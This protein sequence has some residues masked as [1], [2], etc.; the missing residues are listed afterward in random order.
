MQLIDAREDRQIWARALRSHARGFAQAW[1]ANWRRKS[2]TPCA[3]SSRPTKKCAS[4]KSRRPNAD[5][6]ALYLRALPARTGPDT[7]LQDYRRRGGTLLPGDRSSIRTSP[8][9]MPGSPPPA[10]RFII[11]TNRSI[12]G[13]TRRGAKRKPP[14]ACNPNLAKRHFALGLCALLV[15]RQIM[16]ARCANLPS[17]NIFRLT[18][19]TSARCRRHHSSAGALGGIARRLRASRE[20]RPAEPEHRSQSSSTPTRPC[21][22]GPRRGAR[23]ALA[24]DGARIPSSRTSSAA[25]SISGGKATRLRSR[26]L[27]RLLPPGSIRM[28]S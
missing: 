11:S 19:A 20:A 7:L 16:S 22:V 4:R 10:R 9:L 3:P 28:E 13:R 18:T 1:R 24:T 26:K 21:A 14:C 17:R 15:R 6:Y 8:W 5:A 27:W 12:P 25:Y 2:R 23:R